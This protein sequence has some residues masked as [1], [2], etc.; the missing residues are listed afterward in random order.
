MNKTER[1]SG[2]CPQRSRDATKTKNKKNKKTNVHIYFT[3]VSPRPWINQLI[4][5][6]LT[7]EADCLGDGELE[8]VEEAGLDFRLMGTGDDLVWCD[9]MESA[10][11][12][13]KERHWY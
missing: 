9:I 2:R 3:L 6:E 1:R 5:D 4:A 13:K 11:M 7:G 8:K 10:T 12:G